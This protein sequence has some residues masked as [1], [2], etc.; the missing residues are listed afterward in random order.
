MRMINFSVNL[1]GNDVGR[2][3]SSDVEHHDDQYFYIY[4]GR[5]R[6]SELS[7]IQRNKSKRSI[8]VRYQ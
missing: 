2:N 6:H 5:H 7:K 3:L 1:L 4:I 8:F